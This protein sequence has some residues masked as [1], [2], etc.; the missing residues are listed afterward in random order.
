MLVLLSAYGAAYTA[1]FDLDVKAEGYK[2]V[3]FWVKTS[4]MDGSSAATV[5]ITELVKDK[6][7]RIT[8]RR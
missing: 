4:D 2:I 1:S 6:K 7:N 3:S 5:K 8:L